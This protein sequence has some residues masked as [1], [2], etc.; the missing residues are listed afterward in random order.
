MTVDAT[1]P[2]SWSPQSRTTF[3][4]LLSPLLTPAYRLACS[5]TRDGAEA[6]DLLQDAAL[7]AYRGFHSFTPG[8]NFKAWFYRILT[9]R[10]F[11][12]HREARRRPVVTELED[13][14]D[15]YLYARTAEAGLH[16]A[17]DDPAALLMSK[18]TA[19]QIRAAI[20]ELPDEFR[21]VVSLHFVEEMAYQDI[22]EVVGCPVG[23]VRSR[24]HRGRKMLQKKL[25]RIAQ[26]AGI[27]GELTA[28]G[29]G[30]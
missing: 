11:Y 30:S 17:S 5:L 29:D 12:R 9:H 14:P 27:V 20:A 19:E 26:E 7:Q 18:M 3:E 24:L 22:A 15:L 13:S 6:D 1:S 25:W 10:H 21:V 28:S 16:A 2:A 4:S 23:T 8:T